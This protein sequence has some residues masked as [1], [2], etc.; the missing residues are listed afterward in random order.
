MNRKVRFH[1]TM[2][3]ALI[4]AIALLTVIPTGLLAQTPDARRTGEEV[5]YEALLGAGDFLI[6]VESNGCTRKES[7]Q[8]EA[9]KSKNPDGS[10]HYAFTVRR[11]APDECKRMPERVVIHFNLEKDLGITGKYTYSLTNR[12]FP[13]PAEENSLYQLIEKYF[14]LQPGTPRVSEQSRKDSAVSAG[15]ESPFAS[16]LKDELNRLGLQ[17][18]SEL[19]KAMIFAIESEIARYRQRGDQKKVSEL[20]EQ[21]KK[22]QTMA[23]ADFPLPPE[24][25]EQAGETAFQSDGPVLP[26]QV[27]EARITVTKPLRQGAIIEVAGMSKSGPFY[28]LAGSR[29]DILSALTPGQ[30]YDVFLLLIYKR[31]Y[32]GPIPNYY[33]YLAGLREK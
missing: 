19:K 21:L 17:V 1:L 29:G 9:V 31:E 22:F 6:V 4:L 30:K 2:A 23:E 13:A 32:F 7:F 18:R 26:P 27:R 5:L 3:G 11:K 25:P 12:I 33:V 16:A 24:E 20:S 15:M 14:T 10:I 8:V 28:H